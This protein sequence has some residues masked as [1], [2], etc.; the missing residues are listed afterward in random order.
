[1][2]RAVS[3]ERLRS[4]DFTTRREA[5]IQHRVAGGLVAEKRYDPLWEIVD[6]KVPL[7][8]GE[9][10]LDAVCPWCNVTIH[11]GNV[12]VGKTYEC[13]LCGGTIRV[14]AGKGELAVERVE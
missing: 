6:E 4:V 8:G 5:T 13:G 12:T 2:A 3:C 11:L 9:P 14:I 10:D 7:Q 1:L